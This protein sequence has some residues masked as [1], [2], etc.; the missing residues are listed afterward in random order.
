MKTGFDQVIMHETSQMKFWKGDFGDAYTRRNSGD[1]NAEC[2]QQF[3]VTRDSLNEGYLGDLPRSLRILE[4]G[5]NRGKQLELLRG[6]GFSDLWG[7]DINKK[8]L[9]IAKKSPTFN[10]VEASAFDIPYKDN[11]FD[12]V[13]TSDV[14]IHIHPDDLLKA[15]SEIVRVTKRYI[16]GF[17]YYSDTFEQRTYRGHEGKL[18][19][20]DYKSFYIKHFPFL[21]ELKQKTLRDISNSNVDM[22]F[23]LEKAHHGK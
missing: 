16:L 1:F 18:W 11:F 12:M 23:L 9:E 15:L 2:M 20:G 5:C 13:S 22:I 17:E 7:I 6:M 3:G 21:R 10:I 8:A 14:L 4:V 19:R